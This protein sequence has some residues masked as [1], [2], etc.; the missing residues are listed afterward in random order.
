MN[1]MINKDDEG[2]LTDAVLHGQYVCQ[3]ES[4]IIDCK[5]NNVDE[6]AVNIS[7]KCIF[8]ENLIYV[9]KSDILTVNVAEMKRMRRANLRVEKVKMKERI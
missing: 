7:D 9:L 3:F 4:V 2:I 5:I 8:E 1:L 6:D